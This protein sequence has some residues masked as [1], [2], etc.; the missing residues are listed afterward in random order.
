MLEL[1]WDI[2]VNKPGPILFEKVKFW[3]IDSG[4]VVLTHIQCFYHVQW[5]VHE[6]LNGLLFSRIYVC[7]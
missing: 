1:C 5:Y 4:P 7:H 2:K 3:G 6:P